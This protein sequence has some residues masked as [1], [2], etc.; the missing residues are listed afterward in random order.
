MNIKDIIKS[1]RKVKKINRR[2]HKKGAVY[3]FAWSFALMLL[4]NVCFV[5]TSEGARGKKKMDEPFAPKEV[6]QCRLTKIVDGDTVEGLC[7][8]RN[9]RIRLT[10]IDAPER[11][12]KPWGARSTS[13]LRKLLPAKSS[14][15]LVSQGADV[16]HRQLGTIYQLTCPHQ[17]NEKCNVNLQM[18]TTG[19]AV[20]YKGADTPIAYRRAQENAKKK[21]IGIWSKPGL[22]QDP[23]KYRQQTR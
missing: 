10:G 3:I 14:F 12:Q 21:K 13:N 22:Q 5:D 4:F 1:T 15:L 11:A 8:G 7:N 16:Y 18:I 19:Y 2:E 23:K 9:L 20:A 17:N 6:V